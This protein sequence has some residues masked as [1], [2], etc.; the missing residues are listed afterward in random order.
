MTVD[1]KYLPPRIIALKLLLVN[2]EC[3]IQ[4]NHKYVKVNR[5][6]HYIL[7]KELR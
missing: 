6:N 2:N 3:T 4:S 5:T 7:I 1:G